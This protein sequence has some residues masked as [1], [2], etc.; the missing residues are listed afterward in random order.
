VFFGG[1][2]PIIKVNPNA[3][4]WSCTN[5]NLFMKNRKLTISA[6]IDND[7]TNYIVDHALG[8]GVYPIAHNGY[9]DHRFVQ[10]RTDGIARSCV[11]LDHL[12]SS[13]VVDAVYESFPLRIEPEALKTTDAVSTIIGFTLQEEVKVALKDYYSRVPF[14]IPSENVFIQNYST[15]PTASGLNCSMTIPIN[16]GKEIIV[17]FPRNANDLTVFRNPEYHHLQ[18]TLLNRNFPMNGADTTSTEFYRIELESSNLD[19]ILPP[20]QSFENSYKNKVCPEFPYRQRSIGDDTDFLLIFN[21]E[22]QSSNAFFSDPVNSANETIS[23]KGAPKKQDL[24]DVYYI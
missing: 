7:S 23:L 9:Y 14:V 17:L 8:S 2:Q 24:G 13:E 4:V 16:N 5:P 11:K 10:V 15:G 20:T 19:T 1:S 18:L 6:K 21:L 12:M 3:L 22:R